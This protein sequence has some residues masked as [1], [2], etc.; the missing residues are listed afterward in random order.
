MKKLELR[1]LIREE[2]QNV[3]KEGTLMLKLYHDLEQILKTHN[4]TDTASLRDEMEHSDLI[5][6][7]AEKIEGSPI[8]KASKDAYSKAYKVL[9]QYGRENF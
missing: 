8:G 1:Q 3:M 4:V 7:V 6:T 5:D 2:I 9:V